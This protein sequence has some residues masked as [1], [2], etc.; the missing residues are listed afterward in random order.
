MFP[1]VNPGS[2]EY[3]PAMVVRVLPDLPLDSIFPMQRIEKDFFI[4][5][6]RLGNMAR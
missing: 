2:R 1:A 3:T 4:K 5:S 6:R